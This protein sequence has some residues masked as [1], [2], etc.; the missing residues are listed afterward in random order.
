MKRLFVYFLPVLVLSFA[1]C[2]CGRNDVN[3]NA[4]VN[5]PVVTPMITL[6]PS[7]SMMPD[8]NDGEVKDEDGII[9]D[10]DTGST[11]NT[12]SATATPGPS[13]SMTP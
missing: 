4:A 9:E 6:D 13:A 2:G 5:T 8:L 12:T 7:P 10:K 1:L 11:N 3:D